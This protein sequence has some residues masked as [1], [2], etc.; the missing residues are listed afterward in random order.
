MTT[1]AYQT[2]EST[3]RK[4]APAVSDRRN[5]NEAI[6]DFAH[7][8]PEATSSKQRH[9]LM[10][11]IPQVST[12]RT[13]QE[14]ADNSK[15]VKQL[16]Q[17]QMRANAYSS[18]APNSKSKVRT[19]PSILRNSKIGI[20]GSMA[21][22][23]DT[24]EM[25]ARTRHPEMT[26]D[27]IATVSPPPS[28][29]TSFASPPLQRIRIKL[30]HG[31]DNIMNNVRSSPVPEPGT[32]KQDGF[33]DYK[34]DH[35]N[36]GDNENIVLEGHGTYLKD[37]H[38]KGDDYD[39][40]ANL[41][42]RQL[43]NVAF[44]VPKSKNWKGQ[45]ILFGCNTG[46]LTM[47]VSREYLALSQTQVNVVGTLADIRM[48][49]PGSRHQT[50]HQRPGHT[51]EYDR[52]ADRSFP[53]APAENISARQRVRDWVGASL[54]TVSQANHEMKQF[55]LIF[56]ET[57]ANN[58]GRLAIKAQIAGF[59]TRFAASLDEKLNYQGLTYKGI[60]SSSEQIIKIR[61]MLKT[62]ITEL[63]LYEEMLN[64]A[65]DLARLQD[66]ATAF[67]TFFGQLKSEMDVL[68]GLLKA[69]ETSYPDGTVDWEGENVVNSKATEAELPA[70]RQLGRDEI[71]SDKWGGG[72]QMMEMVQELPPNLME[73]GEEFDPVQG[74]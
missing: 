72:G 34:N 47:E 25:A 2:K 37:D 16:A 5:I 67:Q 62:A 15:Q 6:S 49:V 42:P 11:K 44:L 29:G 59:A 7:G 58:V 31:V 63:M 19:D 51:A 13:L 12:L 18:Q 50:G 3:G 28:T 33:T 65:D 46:P 56:E 73:G 55:T 40:Q 71:G 1:Q 43:A 4:S 39:S 26:P 54:L 41:T 32:I 20:G 53:T 30:D 48:E 70:R 68:L 8:G 74:W 23:R 17:F 24:N 57:T 35:R 66:K 14:T 69:A 10:P 9:G 36:I 27:Q 45:I 60:D 61:E 64:E 38:A 22:E 21:L 52:K